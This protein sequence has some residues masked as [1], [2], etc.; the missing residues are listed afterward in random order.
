MK[1]LIIIEKSENGYGAYA[2]DFEGV[3]VVGD[4]KEEVLELIKEAISMQIEDLKEQG[5]D[6]PSPHNEASTVLV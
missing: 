6:I 4:T 3:G 5:L 1:Y 2:P